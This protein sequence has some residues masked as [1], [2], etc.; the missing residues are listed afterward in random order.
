VRDP[1]VERFE[2]LDLAERLAQTFRMDDE[3]IGIHTVLSL[4]F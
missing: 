4:I 2:R 1:Q 3:I